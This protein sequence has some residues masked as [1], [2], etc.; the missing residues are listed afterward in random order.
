M[1]SVL[2]HRLNSGPAA[3]QCFLSD[4]VLCK[5]VCFILVCSLFCK[6]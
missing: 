6:L 1:T 2:K 5:L 4:S 3:S